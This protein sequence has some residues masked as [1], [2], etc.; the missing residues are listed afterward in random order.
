LSTLYR[1]VSDSRTLRFSFV[2][3]P[4]ERLVSAWA[5]KFCNRPL[6]PGDSFIDKYLRH[7]HELDASL[8]QGAQQTLSFA[9]FVIFATATADRRID[10]HWQ[11]QQ[12]ILD[13]PGITLNLVG[14]VETFAADFDRVLDH[15]SLH[16]YRAPAQI[17]PQ[18]QSRHQP[19]PQYYTAALADRVYRAYQ[20][21][22][23]CL[24]YARAI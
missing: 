18:H 4:Y 24:G 7:R 11:L 2:R 19:W 9:D 12:D 22:F 10:A 13:M 6:V 15:L 14:K 20:R 23:D 17:T 21:D 16:R 8:P 5:D 3:N 1:T